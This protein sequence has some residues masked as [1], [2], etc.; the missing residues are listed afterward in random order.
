M[1]GAPHTKPLEFF[2]SE[3]LIAEG[4]RYIP[5]GV[6]SAFRIGMQPGP[7]VF[8]RGEGP[9]FSMSMGTG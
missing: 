8:D 4:S 7:L 1:T 5:G 3:K 2:Q 9:I 6:N